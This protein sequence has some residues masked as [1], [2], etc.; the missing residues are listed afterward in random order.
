MVVCFFQDA[1]AVAGYNGI[2]L[3]SLLD[4]QIL[5]EHSIPAPPTGPLVTGDFNNDGITD[6]ILTCKMG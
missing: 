2:S 1:I 3:V 4:G 6:I 5:A